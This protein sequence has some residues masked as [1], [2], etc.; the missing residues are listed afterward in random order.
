MVCS[1][2]S[3][4]F[5]LQGIEDFLATGLQS[6]A[7]E[8]EHLVRRLPG[9]DGLDHGTGGLAMQIADN[10]AKPDAAVGQYLVQP[11]LLRGQLADQ[12]LPLASNQT[13]FAPLRRRHERAAQQPRACQRRQPVGIAHIR[14]AA[15]DVL[16]MPGIHHLRANADCFQRRIRALPVDARALHD[17]FVRTQRCRPVSEFAAIPPEAAELPLLDARV[18]VRVLDQRTGGDLRLM[19]VETDD[20]LVQCYQFHAASCRF[21]LKGGRWRVPD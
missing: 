2:A 19:D 5:A 11:V 7:G 12:F 15:R 1:S 10:H 9:D 17:D 4:Q 8:T 16:D 18:A 20:A 14:L 21:T 13:Q 3:V 6:A